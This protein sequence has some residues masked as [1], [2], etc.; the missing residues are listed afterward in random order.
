MA[1]RKRTTRQS[2]IVGRAVRAGRAALREARAGAAGPP[3]AARAKDQGRRQGSERR[4]QA[5]SVAGEEGKHSRR[6]QQRAEANRQP[7]EASASGARGTSSRATSTRR[8]ATATTRR[9]AGTAK[10]AAATTR[11]KVTGRASSATR[12]PPRRGPRRAPQ[13]QAARQ[14]RDVRPVAYRPAPVP[15]AT[16]ADRAAPAVSESTPAMTE[17]MAPDEGDIIEI[18]EID[19]LTES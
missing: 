9:T 17:T 2:G 16:P 18:I 4:D 13:L 10:K 5:A 11:R 19:E 12:K 7:D 6:R 3:P 14:L 1:K 8:R 15:G